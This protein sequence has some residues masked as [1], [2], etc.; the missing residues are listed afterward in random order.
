MRSLSANVYMR[1]YEHFGCGIAAGIDELH[2]P[3]HEAIDK[4][5]NAIKIPDEIQGEPTL[6]P[7]KLPGAQCAISLTLLWPDKNFSLKITNPMPE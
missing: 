2:S 6:E 3:R 4:T 5:L 7:N 1:T